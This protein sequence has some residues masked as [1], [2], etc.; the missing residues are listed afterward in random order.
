MTYIY[1]SD[2]IQQMNN[3]EKIVISGVGVEKGEATKWEKRF[4]SLA[5]EVAGWS[6][7]PSAKVGCVLATK[8]NRVVSLGY[9]GFPAGYDDSVLP[10]ISREEKLANTIHAELNAVLNANSS[11]AGAV[12][13]VTHCCC[14]SCCAVL[15][16]SK[17]SSVV[18]TR[19]DAGF[20]AR[21]PQSP[22]I[23]R[24]ISA[25]LS[26]SIVA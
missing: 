10:D 19:P 14:L 13:Y 15:V 4:L 21:W 5:A 23:Q 6:K 1:R 9:N 17:I 11:V 7:D 20:E 16:Q 25:G 24:L 12:A 8:D 18:W 22:A 3:G 2:D 26:V